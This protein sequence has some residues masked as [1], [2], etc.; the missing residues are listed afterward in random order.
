MQITS[1]LWEPSR[2]VISAVLHAA[3][4][5]RLADCVCRIGEETHESWTAI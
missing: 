4:A 1:R 3:V 5:M 2:F